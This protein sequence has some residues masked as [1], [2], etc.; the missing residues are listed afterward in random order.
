MQRVDAISGALMLVPRAAFATLGGCSRNADQLCEDFVSDCG[1]HN[2]L[3]DCQ[4]RASALESQAEEKGCIDRY[5]AYVDCVDELS[6]LCETAQ[7]CAAE[8]QSLD[9]C[10]VFFSMF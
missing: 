6:S 4:M 3:G 8:R 2:D 1:E 9:D 7:A 10:G 5:F